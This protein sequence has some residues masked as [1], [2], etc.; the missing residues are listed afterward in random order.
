M[1]SYTEIT[2]VNEIQIAWKIIEK[3]QKKFNCLFPIQ[4]LE[5]DFIEVGHQESMQHFLKV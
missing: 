4:D 5:L 1:F 3:H 2:D